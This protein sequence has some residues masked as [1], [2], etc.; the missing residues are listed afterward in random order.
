VARGLVVTLVA[1]LHGGAWVPW[2]LHQ[3][4]APAP[5]FDGI[6]NNLSY[7]P[8]TT[9]AHPDHEGGRPP[10]ERIRAELKAIAPYTKAIRL[11]S[12]TG[13]VEQVPKIAAEF[14]LKVWLGIWLDK[15]ERRGPNGLLLS[16]LDP[17]C[18]GR[19]EQEM[20]GVM[21]VPCSS[22]NIR[23]IR[24]AL[25][26][27]HTNRN[28]SALMVGNETLFRHDFSTDQLTDVVRRVK[29]EVATFSRVPVSTGEIFEMLL[30]SD[31][32]RAIQ[33]LVSAIDFV[34]AHVLPYWGGIP[35]ENAVYE[36][37]RICRNLRERFPGKRI[38]IAEFGWPSSG[39]HSPRRSAVPGRSWQAAI[40]RGFA[41]R[42]QAL[43]IDYNLLEAYDQPWMATT[44]V[45]S[46]GAHW[47][48]Y[49]NS[50]RPKFAWAGPLPD[51]EAW[52]IL[53]IAV[54]AGI[55]LSLPILGLARQPGAGGAGGQH[56][57]RLRGDRIRLRLSSAISSSKTLPATVV[58]NQN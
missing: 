39:W 18:K 14:G 45:G 24:S 5:D 32:D 33:R 44:N 16:E 13:G 21:N 54:A 52:K 53:A 19:F 42:A 58:E 6:L 55:L 28:V 8:F 37:E 2:V 15:S 20:S 23:E 38:V 27:L 35:G 50:R 46:A 29:R 31:D 11:Y 49:D 1:C 57:W 47:G 56:R 22:R 40:M 7:S 51:P 34:A 4:P 9:T 36:T 48:L 43:G 17:D 12:S 10:E 25:D 30:A 26:L 3:T 41:V